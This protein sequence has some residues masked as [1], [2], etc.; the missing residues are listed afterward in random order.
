MDEMNEHFSF[1][2][3]LNNSQDIGFVIL[4]SY[5]S[6]YCWILDCLGKISVEQGKGYFSGEQVKKWKKIA[7]KISNL[8]HFQEGLT[9]S[10]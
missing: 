8:F 7:S 9:A 2:D 5:F 6:I 10:L 4:E 3:I 1:L